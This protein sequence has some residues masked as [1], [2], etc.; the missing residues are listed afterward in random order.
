MYRF[1]LKGIPIR[2]SV[3]EMITA[4]FDEDHD[5]ESLESKEQEP[6]VIP[7]RVKRNPVFRWLFFIFGA[8]IPATKLFTLYGIAL[9]KA[10]GVMFVVSFAL[11][12]VYIYISKR[13]RAVTLSSHDFNDRGKQLDNTLT[14]EALNEKFSGAGIIAI[15]LQ[16]IL[17]WWGA[18]SVFDRIA[19]GFNESESPTSRWTTTKRNVALEL[20][21]ASVC[22]FLEVEIVVFTLLVCLFFW[23]VHNIWNVHNSRWKTVQIILSRFLC[24]VVTGAACFGTYL[25]SFLARNMVSAWYP[26]LISLFWFIVLVLYLAVYLLLLRRPAILGYILPEFVGFIRT[27]EARNSSEE[28]TGWAIRAIIFFLLHIFVTLLWYAVAYNPRWTY[29]ASWTFALGELARMAGVI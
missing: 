8:L 5:R 6:A 4:R 10:W 11:D 14:P 13:Q 18:V 26:L 24:L 25:V 9:S 23:D 19:F 12:E 27:G 20:N 16:V 28:E 29:N 3:L 1:L 21:T 2:N 15:M 7:R 22:I 17:V